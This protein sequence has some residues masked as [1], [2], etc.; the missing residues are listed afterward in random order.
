MARSK[1]TRSGITS[2]LEGESY[3]DE[4][5]PRASTTETPDL[6]Y[7]SSTSE[8]DF[9]Q[10]SLSKRGGTMSRAKAK[11]ARKEANR[12]SYT[13]QGPSKFLR[14]CQDIMNRL[15]HDA[16]FQ[17]SDYMVGYLDRHTGV[18]E[19]ALENWSFEG[20]E[21]EDFIPMHRVTYIRSVPNNR[22]VWDREMKIDEIF[23]SGVTGEQGA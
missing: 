14:P 9:P 16:A 22:L 4:A 21:D 10:V 5:F 18:M 15:R 23:Q 6:E 13:Q 19:K 20:V 2:E 7:L 11:R 3:G 1:S 8:S 12:N 17:V